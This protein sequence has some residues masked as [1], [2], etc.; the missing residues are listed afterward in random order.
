MPTH[1]ETLKTGDGAF[2]VF[3][4]KPDGAGPWAGVVVLQ[5]IFGVNPVVREICQSLAQDGYLAVAPDLFWRIEPGVD[6]TDQSEAEW[7]KAFA[8]LNAFDIDKGLDDIQTTIDWVRKQPDCTG[9][10]GAVGHCL[11]GQLA[12][13]TATRTDA[14]VSVAYYGVGIE[15]RLGEAAKIHNPL[16][17]HIA[18][19]D[20]FVSPAAQAQIRAALETNPHVTIH[21]YPGR[22]HAF[23]RPGGQNFH[24]ADAGLANDRTLSFLKA[25]Q[26]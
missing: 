18:E 20:G 22:D 1:T 12:F 7:K 5:E 6:I 26:L 23:A 9:R 14:D 24:R 2:D 16:L 4:A 3:V 8:L 10:V 13:L 25:A 21:S 19:A 17:L 15:T 11:G